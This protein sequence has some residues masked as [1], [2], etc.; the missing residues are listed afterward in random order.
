MKK[1]GELR[2]LANLGNENGSKLHRIKL[3]LS[4]ING[5]EVEI[6]GEKVKIIVDFVKSGDNLIGKFE[7]TDIFYNH[8]DMGIP[9]WKLSLELNKNNVKLI[10]DIDDI[11][12]LNKENPIYSTFN[13]GNIKRYLTLADVIIVSNERLK[14]HVERF[15]KFR[16]EDDFYPIL[17]N[18]NHLPNEGQWEY[19][20]KELHQ[21]KVRFG[22][23]GSIS[24]YPDWKLLK[25]MIKI[26]GNNK[27]FAKKAKFVVA[28]YG[29]DKYWKEIL[30][31]FK[32]LKCEV[33]FIPKRD[34]NNYMELLDNVDVMLAPL[35]N[36]EFSY[37]KSSLKIAECAMR[38]VF[39]V[40]SL[41]YTGKDL[42]CGIVIDPEDWQKWIWELLKDDKWYY[43]G[44]EFGEK[45]RNV[46]N[47]EE[48]VNSLTKAIE[49]CIVSEYGEPENVKIY[50]I[51]YDKEQYTEFTPY[52]NQTKNKAWRFEYNVM[53]DIVNNL[54]DFD[55]YLG[56]FSWKFPM[57]TGI[58]KKVLH[59]AVEGLGEDVIGLSAPYFK[60]NYLKFSYEQHPGLKEI[61]EKVCNKLNLTLPKEVDKVVYSNFFLAKTEV[62][63]QYVNDV[64]VPVLDF[65]ENNP[66]IFHKDANYKHGLTPE[67][68]KE[69]TGLDFYT[70]HTFVLERM[71]S[72]WLYNNPQIT[73]KQLI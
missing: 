9:S 29:N 1:Q 44:K 54:K 66:E 69:Y 47:F 20:P 11:F 7:E 18:N 43:L 38:D 52:F 3:P 70:W 67:K 68:L 26:L 4:A 62:Y 37:N 35:V 60:N 12:Y 46:M 19:K 39:L 63:K 33:D 5:R 2:I 15:S 71:L 25:G 53:L 59:K 24:H 48:R 61:L 51:T 31:W 36:D 72:I 73:F 10:E 13:A 23:F 41:P 32:G 14:A 22:I 8:F 57:K 16:K 21:G 45:N 40:G 17:V 6:N 64:V 28:G 49:Y 34:S 30:G 55:G 27:E 42:S 56:I 50:G 58:C 65:M